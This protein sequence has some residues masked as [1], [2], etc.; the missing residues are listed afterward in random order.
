MTITVRLP[1]AAKLRVYGPAPRSSNSPSESGVRPG[2]AWTTMAAAALYALF[3]L[4]L[5]R[6]GRTPKSRLFAVFNSVIV[7]F[8]LGFVIDDPSQAASSIVFVLLVPL[9]LG[10]ADKAAL[11]AF[12]HTLTDQ[13][14]LRP[15]SISATSLFKP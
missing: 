11:I 14:F 3:V 4:W 6:G 2:T 12:L 8:P 15:G 13:A 1:S 9:G 7:L 5:F 10:A